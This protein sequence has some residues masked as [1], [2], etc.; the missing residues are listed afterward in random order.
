MCGRQQLIAYLPWIVVIVRRI[1]EFHVHDIPDLF[2][3]PWGSLSA[4][5]LHHRVWDTAGENYENG[6]QTDSHCSPLTQ[7]RD[8]TSDPK[9]LSVA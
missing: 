2:P 8:A 3:K 5:G 6:G 7:A 4:C 1:K 9:S